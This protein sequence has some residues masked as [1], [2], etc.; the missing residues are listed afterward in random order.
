MQT[1]ENLHNSAQCPVF[2][3]GGLPPGSA[4]KTGRTFR[5]ALGRKM[6][7]SRNQNS[8]DLKSVGVRSGR[9]LL[10]VDGEVVDE[11]EVRLEASRIRAEFLQ[12]TNIADPVTREIRLRDAARELVIEGILLR[13]AAQTAGGGD[14]DALIRRV[15]QA[16][17]RPRYAEILKY[18]EQYIREFWQPASVHA[19]HIVKNV[20]EDADQESAR[21]A[22]QS[23]ESELAAGA[24][25][26]ALADR[27]S[28]CKGDG[29][30]LGWIPLGAMV[31]EFEAVVF[32]L[33]PGQTS[34]IFRTAFGF[35]IAR[36]FA[37]RPEGFLPFDQV[38]TRIDDSLFAQRKRWAVENFV[39]DLKRNAKFER[40]H[41]SLL[42]S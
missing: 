41:E 38:R 6:N 35:H 34:G 42:H 20:E 8:S 3:Y 40:I 26:A 12:S 37:R 27:V 11:A 22:I 5:F 33:Q 39:A 13:H 25:F 4:G 16:A 31:P 9:T 23:I 15:M 7:N 24:D 10:I 17:Y 30:D 18:Y 32:A 2:L 19:G 36:V 14:V 21:L 28:D 29:G 1:P